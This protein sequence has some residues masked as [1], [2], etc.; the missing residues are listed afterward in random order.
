MAEAHGTDLLTVFPRVRLTISWERAFLPT[1]GLFPSYRLDRSTTPHPRMPT[2]SFLLFRRTAFDA[3]GGYEYLIWSRV[4]EDW[5][6]AKRV[7]AWASS[8]TCCSRP[9]S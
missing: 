2:R 9:S 4:G 7:K 6:I 3:M 1:L 8:S 5:I